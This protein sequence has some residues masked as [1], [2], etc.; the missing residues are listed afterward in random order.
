M[1][2]GCVFY[3]NGKKYRK[4]SSVKSGNFLVETLACTFQFC[5][6]SN[7]FVKSSVLKELNGFD[8]S[9]VRHQDYEFLVRFFENHS[10][11]AVKKPLIKKNETY[12]NLPNIYK[13]IDVKEHYLS[14]YK[15]IIDKLPQEKK[16]Y[17]YGSNYYEICKLALE[18]NNLPVFKRY[19]N[20]CKEVKQLTLLRRIKLFI[21]KS[22][23][24][25]NEKI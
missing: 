24:S 13:I 4:L 21:I 12:S 7:L 10:L 22:F 9:F 2:S 16:K 8:T 3:K 6:G 19:L 14:K 17:I 23:K 15:Y 18:T 25:R 11:I 5:S 20:M 1:Y